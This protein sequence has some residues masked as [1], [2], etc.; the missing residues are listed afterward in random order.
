MNHIQLHPTL[1]RLQDLTNGAIG[2]VNRSIIR[3]YFLPLSRQLSTEP[4]NDEGIHQAQTG[5]T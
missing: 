1:L 2:D 5:H 4:L 3:R